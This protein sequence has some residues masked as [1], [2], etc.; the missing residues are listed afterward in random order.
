MGWRDW[1]RT[2]E[3]EPSLYA[4]DFWQ[5]RRADPALAH[6]GAR[7][8]H[9]DIGDGHFVPPV[10]I[11]P[12]VLRSIAPHIHDLGG[13]IDC[14][15]MVDDPAHHFQE[16]AES[17]GDSVTFHVEVVD[18]VG[19]V[20]A[21][22]REHGLEVGV[23]FNPETPVEVA[24]EAAAGADLCLCMSIEPG[25]SGQEFMEDA[26]E[27]IARTRELV[28][29]FVQVDGGVKPENV[30]AVHE[31]GADLLVV[32][33]GIFGFE[34][35]PRRLPA[36]GTSPG[37]SMERALELAAAADGRA[38]PKP[39]IG[40]VVVAGGE[41]VG[42][43]ATEADGRHG[44]VVALAAAGE[45]ARGATLYVTM[46]PCAHHGTTPPCVDAVLAAGVARVVA[47][48]L[49][50]ESGGGRRARAAAASRASRPSSSTASRRAAR[51]R[52]GARG[53]R[54]AARSSPTRPR[55]RSTAASP[56][57]ASAGSPARSRAGSCTS[58]APPR[59]RSR[60]GWARSGSRTRG[61]TRATSMRRA[62]RAGS[63]SAAARSPRAPSSSSA[64]A[65]SRTSCARSPPRASSRSCSRA[66]RR[67]RARSSRPGSSTSCS[68]SSRRRSPATARLVVPG[69]GGPLRLSHLTSRQVG[70]DV[71]LEAYLREP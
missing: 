10:T 48:S 26:Y 15:L 35:L 21:Q 70:D 7:I 23:A 60:S 20:I 14:H 40:A 55:S 38:Y 25:Y 12:V 36:A 5:P 34:D 66:A 32:G 2:V 6:A 64:A 63:R 47:G 67:S 3:I 11:G 59:T 31:A 71:L 57:R 43:G 17:G 65:R 54:S 50:P 45:R 8:F 56:S 13:R 41:V 53:C 27:R 52:R 9:F 68:S 51:T 4:A 46:E 58:C 22:A 62:S 49:D 39:T 33:T 29:C 24:A 18:D 30:R 28:D 1:V 44:E 42:E 61:S 19:A 16:I 69:L 37:M